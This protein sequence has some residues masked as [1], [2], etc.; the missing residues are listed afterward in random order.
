[1]RVVDQNIWL[2]LVTRAHAHH[3]ET[4]HW[5]RRLDGTAYFCRS[6]QQGLLRLLT[7]ASVFAHYAL[8]PRSQDQAWEI[9]EGLLADPKIDFLPEP[10]SVEKRWKQLTSSPL[11][12]PKAW[13]EAWLAAVAI[14][15]EMPLTT[16]D[17]GFRQFEKHGLQLELLKP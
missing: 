9:Y 15:A 2:A 1:M 12:S 14:T 16:F 4:L 5:W 7:T 10:A 3:A 8:P 6:T 17:Q 13:M 11:S